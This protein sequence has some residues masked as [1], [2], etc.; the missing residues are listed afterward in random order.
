[1]KSEGLSSEV[2]MFHEVRGRSIMKS[3]GLNGEV[4]MFY[5]SY[6]SEYHEVRG[7]ELCN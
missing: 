7:P 6:I 4:R 5:I 2:R 3:E 1:M